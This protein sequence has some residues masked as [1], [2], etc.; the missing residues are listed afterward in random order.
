MIKFLLY[1]FESGL[2]LSIL[3]LVYIFFFRKETYF[4]FNRLYLISIMFL[5]LLIPFMHVNLNVSDTRNYESAING[6]GKFKNYYER[7]I[8]MSDTDYYN[9]HNQNKYLEFEGSG[10]G[11]I[12]DLQSNKK[13]TK[14]IIS[15]EISSVDNNP[16]FNFSISKL[17]FVIYLAGVF[18]FLSR[19]ILLFRWIYKI[20]KANPKEKWQKVTIVKLNKDLP[21][22]SFLSYIFLKKDLCSNNKLEQI[23]AHEKE[24]IKQFHSV[25]LLLAHFITTI[26]WFNPFVWLLHKAIKTNHEYLADKSVVGKGYNL[27]DY[28][29]LLLKEFITIPSVQLVN[30]FNLVSIK[31]RIHM[32]NKIKSGFAAKLKALLIIPAAIFT[33]ILFANLTLN[34]PGKVLTNLSFFEIQNNMNQL[35]GLWK[36]TSDNTYGYQVL[37]ENQKFSV[38]DHNII[39]KEYPYQLESNQIILSTPGNETIDLKYEIASNQLKIWWNQTEYSLYNKSEYTN[40]LD[41]YLSTIDEPINLPV[42]ENYWLLQRLSLCIDVAM[43]KDKIYVNKILTDYTKLKDALLKEKSKIN[44]LDANLITIRIYADKDLSMEYMYKLNQVL[45]E[46]GILKVA[47]MGKVNDDKVSKLHRGYIG[48]TKKLPPMK[49]IEIIEKEELADRGIT[50]FEMDATKPDNT[51]DVLKP[52]FEEIMKKSEKYVASLLY[53]KTTIFNTYIGF[54]DMARSVVFEYRNKYAAEKYNLKFDEL[55]SIQQKEIRKIYPLIISEAESFKE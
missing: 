25:D 54:Q 51:P 8:A 32:M 26:Q 47:H 52:K 27:L 2:C 49:G 50:Y 36:N 30:N 31:N 11:E 33:F 29:E 24:H 1:L 6:I 39:L 10:I 14:Q 20:I 46:I 7:L 23:L 41:D 38:L 45:R 17:I 35:K 22:F 9:T 13:N 42:I 43:V 55:S 37:F 16:K 12:S 53:D 19:I 48:M 18:I 4:R 5:S 34:G 44:H 28:Q 3:I 15:E 21:P 40:S